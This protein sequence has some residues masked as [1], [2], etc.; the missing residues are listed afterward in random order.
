MHA[1]TALANPLRPTTLNSV[2][3]LLS[4]LLI[5]LVLSLVGAASGHAQP[6]VTASA[7]EQ[8]SL[9][10]QVKASRN[11]AQRKISS[12]LLQELDQQRGAAYLARLP[13]LQPSSLLNADGTFLIDMTAT[14]DS[15][16]LARAEALGATVINA[17]PQWNS[18]R[19]RLPLDALEDLA[20]ESAVKSL[21]AADL[22]MLQMT[23]TTEGDIAHGTAAVRAATGADGSG[24]K[25][26]SMS[27]SVESLAALQG[28]GDLPAG[29]TVLAGQAGTGTSEGTALMEIVHDMAP[30]SEL[31]F[32]TGQGGQAQMAQNIIDLAAAGCR[33]IN[34]DILYFVESVFQ[35]GVIAQ[36]VDQVVAAGVQYFSAAS[37]SGNLDAGTA[38]VWEGEFV[39]T[40]LP[41][42]LVGAAA[43]AHDFGGGVNNNLI[44]FDAPV[45]I[46]LQ[47]SNPLGAASDDFDLFVLDAALANVVA[48]STSVQDGDDDP[49]EVIDSTAR[50]DAGNRLVI[51]QFGGGPAFLHVNTHRGMLSTATDGQIFGHPAAVGAM[52]VA[53]INV[54]TAGGGEFVGGL[55]VPVE[56]FSSD[57]PRRIFFDPTGAPIAAGDDFD[58]RG[59]PTGVVRQKPDIT[60]ADGVSTATPGF[61]PFFGTSASAPH[62]AGISALYQDLFPAVPADVANDLFKSSALDIDQTGFDRNSGAGIVN[63]GGAVNE[64]IFS[65][66]FESGDTAAWSK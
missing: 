47:W 31:F 7:A 55:G 17:F 53:A 38:G 3:R 60:A 41:T 5:G 10:Q 25:V 50:D 12:Q 22:Y 11:P 21:R 58:L 37:N 2:E 20:A 30:G 52:A 6:Q 66:G 57:G 18:A 59:I 44:T 65:D 8:I 46:T 56:A 63:M 36:A 23:N 29:V 48:F 49:L 14:V 43:A 62:A 35:D 51:T 19:L 61:D 16:L 45:L 32:A 42:P 39:A 26:G 4:V 64:T 24:V 9:V 15:D 54:A 1:E 34:D 40:S 27:D 33:V 28:T 13:K